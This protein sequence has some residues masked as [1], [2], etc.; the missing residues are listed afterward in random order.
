[1]KFFSKWWKFHSAMLISLSLVLAGCGGAGG[2]GSGDSG[3]KG[4]GS[5]GNN[6]IPDNTNT[7][8][9]GNNGSGT[10]ADNTNNTGVLPV[11]DTGKTTIFVDTTNAIDDLSLLNAGGVPTFGKRS[12][13]EKSLR[14][15]ASDIN[16]IWAVQYSESGEIETIYP[17]TKSGTKYSFS[18]DL[19][20]TRGYKFVFLGYENSRWT[21]SA[22]EVYTGPTEQT[23]TIG[24]AGPTNELNG[25]SDGT[26]TSPFLRTASSSATKASISFVG[27]AAA[28]VKFTAKKA[29]EAGNAI[30]VLTQET[31]RATYYVGVI[32]HK[33]ATITANNPFIRYRTQ[34]GKIGNVNIKFQHHPEFTPA[35][36][37]PGDT[38]PFPAATRTYTRAQGLIDMANED[39]SM[40]EYSTYDVSSNTITIHYGP[41]TTMQTVALLLEVKNPS[42]IQRADVTNSALALDSMVNNQIVMGQ[43]E[44]ELNSNNGN[45]SASGN[46]DGVATN[47]AYDAGSSTLFLNLQKTNV[48]YSVGAGSFY[49]LKGTPTTAVRPTA[50]A[51][52]GTGGFSSTLGSV[53][54]AYADADSNVRDLVDISLVGTITTVATST[55]SSAVVLAS[56]KLTG[57][58]NPSGSTAVQNFDKA[59][60]PNFVWTDALNLFVPDSSFPASTLGLRSGSGITPKNPVGFD[61]LYKNFTY[62]GIL[63]LKAADIG[64]DKKS[65]ITSVEAKIVSA[66]SYRKEGNIGPAVTSIGNDTF[67]VGAPTGEIILNIRNYYHSDV[68]LDDLRITVGIKGANLDSDSGKVSV[69]LPVPAIGYVAADMAAST[70]ATPVANVLDDDGNTLVH[71]ALLT[72]GN[73]N[74]KT[75]FHALAL[76]ATVGNIVKNVFPSFSTSTVTALFAHG[77]I[78]KQDFTITKKSRSPLVRLFQWEDETTVAFG[79]VPSQAAATDTIVYDQD[80]DFTTASG[81]RDLRSSFISRSGTGAGNFATYEANSGGEFIDIAYHLYYRPRS[82]V[83]TDTI[84]VFIE[85]GTK[86][87]TGNLNGPRDS[88]IVSPTLVGKIAE[89]H[90][91]T[92][93]LDGTIIPYNG[94]N[95]DLIYNTLSLEIPVDTIADS[96]ESFLEEPDAL[97]SF[98]I[99]FD[100]VANAGS[101]A[102]QSETDPSTMTVRADLINERAGE[103]YTYRW[104]WS[105]FFELAGDNAMI[106][107]PAGAVIHGN[108]KHQVTFSDA[109]GKHPTF[110]TVKVTIRP[111]AGKDPEGTLRPFDPSTFNPTLTYVEN[112]DRDFVFYEN[113]D[114]GTDALNMSVGGYKAAV[115][116]DL[117][118]D[119]TQAHVIITPKT[120]GNGQ[121]IA[122]GGEIAEA[123]RYYMSNSSKIATLVVSNSSFKLFDVY[124]K[125]STADATPYFTTVRASDANGLVLGN[126]RTADDNAGPSLDIKFAN[127][128]DYLNV[129]ENGSPVL[130]VTI[131]DTVPS[132][133]GSTFIVNLSNAF[134]PVLETPGVTISDV[135]YSFVSLSTDGVT[136]SSKKSKTNTEQFLSVANDTDADGAVTFNM[137]VKRVN[138]GTNDTQVM[139]N[140]SK[141]VSGVALGGKSTR[142]NQFVA[143]WEVARVSDQGTQ[144]LLAPGNSNLHDWVIAAPV[145]FVGSGADGNTNSITY[146]AMYKAVYN[147][148]IS[149]ALAKPN[150][151]IAQA[152]AAASAAMEGINGANLTLSQAPGEFPGTGNATGSSNATTALTVTRTAVITRVQQAIAAARVSNSAVTAQAAA[153]LPVTATSYPAGSAVVGLNS[154]VFNAVYTAVDV[155]DTPLISYYLALAGSKAVDNDSLDVTA[156]AERKTTYDAVYSAVNA[157]SLSALS[158]VA[159]AQNHATIAA[160]AAAAGCSQ[161]NI[162]LIVASLPGAGATLAGT[163]ARSAV[164]TRRAALI[165]SVN[166]A[167]TTAVNAEKPVLTISATTVHAAVLAVW[168]VAGTSSATGMRSAVYNAIFTSVDT[169]E[170]PTVARRIAAAGCAP[171]GNI[172]EDGKNLIPANAQ[173]FNLGNKGNAGEHDATLATDPDDPTNTD[174]Q[175]MLFSCRLILPTAASARDS[176]MVN[177]RFRPGVMSNVSLPPIMTNSFIITVQE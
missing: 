82:S 58:T 64:A 44:S 32:G 119:P 79:F 23:T 25:V 133:N 121:I 130:S 34:E 76:G 39:F 1:M 38:T 62:F 142:E 158:T 96:T 67:T 55:H 171:F 114:S 113:Y 137:R 144:K 92:V 3:T 69:A 122:S 84:T 68:S 2:E 116:M 159:E 146:D 109:T 81:G 100:A 152:S 132:H 88:S 53:M 26:G 125:G 13:G 153:I 149:I 176:Y 167:I 36:L 147:A 93:G 99:V 46:T 172:A 63:H 124:A 148:V 54:Q 71:A 21:G 77:D 94:S 20:N 85:D 8:G 177:F 139:Q 48:P 50:A 102:G 22:A 61:N 103:T 31:E 163:T 19:S 110:A 87:P 112:V 28:G 164:A 97:V 129:R 7:A 104:N 108:G 65:K 120:N 41:N 24:A 150:E 145:D 4:N 95:K 128:D 134:P 17:T 170:T 40:Y 135:L 15:T 27:E 72:A 141:V 18:A 166:A 35:L 37:Q 73:V 30:S 74:T 174:L 101:T 80:S 78:A 123:I 52:A 43:V 70:N 45:L 115:K 86:D 175:H 173:K 66:Q 117:T 98:S 90:S 105:R 42:I 75:T 138:A 10:V 11:D 127:S 161:D 47:M 168:P 29:G 5:A 6:S 154:S 143:H 165:A 126:S 12:K 91:P 140:S 89:S 169:T 60:N 157:A 156:T 131:L 33:S 56:R 136:A 111:N 151:A 59:T 16:K 9:G 162:D 107:M 14:G 49:L 83:G 118:T 57:G 160:S 155:A 51:N 106:G